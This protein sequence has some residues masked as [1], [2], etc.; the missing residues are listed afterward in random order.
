MPGLLT[1]EF[2]AE[3]RVFHPERNE[4]AF[5]NM[6]GHNFG[7]CVN[8]AANKYPGWVVTDACEPLFVGL[9]DMHK[10]NHD[11]SVCVN[12]GV[13]EHLAVDELCSGIYGLL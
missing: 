3:L 9:P 13:H 2:T 1:G 10:W 8:K 4:V 7:E 5:V 11:G 12:C 6:P